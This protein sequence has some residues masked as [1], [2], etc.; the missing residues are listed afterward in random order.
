[1]CVTGGKGEGPAR[2]SAHFAIPVGLHRGNPQKF[3]EL[4]FKK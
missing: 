3:G 2:R 4:V 1:M